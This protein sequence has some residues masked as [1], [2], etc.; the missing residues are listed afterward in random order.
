MK[1]T[2]KKILLAIGIVIILISFLRIYLYDDFSNAI[3]GGNYF[4]AFLIDI[5]AGNYFPLLPYLGFG[6]IGAYFGLI[7][8]DNPSKKKIRR[9]IWIGVGW[10]VAAIVAFIIPDSIYE[11]LGLLD[12]IFFDYIIVMFEIGFFIVVG[13]PLLLVF[14]N[15]RGDKTNPSHRDKKKI[16]TIFLRF[17]TNSLT[18]FLL[19]RPISEIFALILNLSIPGWNN[20]IWTSILY[21]LFL[22][23]FWFIII[24]RGN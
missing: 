12:D 9:M 17:S 21:G 18:F 23:L 15:K 2:I 24:P 11:T 10:I 7:L 22:V 5:I 1:K 19:E 3:D 8:A 16:S 14:F 6:L 4:V 20:Y 13:I